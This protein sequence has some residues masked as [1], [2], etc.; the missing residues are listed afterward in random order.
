[1]AGVGSVQRLTVAQQSETYF[2]MTA[3]GQSNNLSTDAV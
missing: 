1:M 2:N 3:K